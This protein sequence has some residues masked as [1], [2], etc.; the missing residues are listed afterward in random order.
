MTRRGEVIAAAAAAIPTPHGSPVRV[1]IDGMTGVGKSTFIQELADALR[2]LG[3]KV[4]TASGDDFHHQR[5][6]R[7]RQ[8]RHSARG[9]FEDAYDYQ[10]MADKLLAPLAPGGSR[11][12]RLRHHDLV[13]DAILVD[14]PVMTVDADAVLLVEGSFLQ[15]PE[16]APHWDFVIL[17]EATRE[18]SALRQVTRD[19]APADPEDPYHARYF[20]AYDIYVDQMRPRDRA[21][22]VIDNTDLDAPVLLRALA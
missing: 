17:L 4:A 18:A 14:E 20:G 15:R 5:E 7:Y 19:G 8:G 16:A 12:V 1:A 11:E 9:Y 22:V 6:V 10:A 13:S 21:D 3:A 2:A